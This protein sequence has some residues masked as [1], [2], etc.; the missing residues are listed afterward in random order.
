MVFESSN[1]FHCDPRGP[2]RDKGDK[3]PQATRLFLASAV[4]LLLHRLPSFTTYHCRQNFGIYR[5]ASFVLCHGGTAPE[6]Q[7]HFYERAAVPRCIHLSLLALAPTPHIGGVSSAVK[8]ATGQCRTI[9]TS[10]GYTCKT[11]FYNQ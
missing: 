8:D 2:E 1:Y 6:H 3:Y 9:L 7:N 11:D 5:V 10:C 4:S